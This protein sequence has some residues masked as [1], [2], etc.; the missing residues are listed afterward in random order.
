MIKVIPAIDIIGG[1]CVRLTEGDYGR[2]REYGDPFD[3][4]LR[5]ADHGVRRL[6]VVDL[7]GAKEGKVVNYKIIEQ[8]ASGTKLVID[9]GGGVKTEED[10]RI[11]FNS[12]ASMVTGGSIAVKDPLRFEEWVAV[13]GG[14]KIILGSDFRNGRIAVS[15]WSEDSEKKLLPFIEEW[16][17]K[18]I[19]QTICTDISKDGVLQ[20]TSEAIYKEIIKKFPGLF[21]I[22]SGGVSGTD[23]I[24]SLDEAGIPAVVVGKAIYEGRISLKDIERFIE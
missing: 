23:D 12:G 14:D 16:M 4:A 6:H 8:I 21:L 10:L 22:A 19:T 7:D 15:G 9:A 20:G 2:K 13:Y 3:M 24:I 18:G 11:L 5:F 17:K 1:K